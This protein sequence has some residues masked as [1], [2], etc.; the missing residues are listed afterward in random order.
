MERLA[1]I[2]TAKLEAKVGTVVDAFD[3]ELAVVRSMADAPQIDGLV[4][5]QNGAEAG[6]KPGDFAS[7]RSWA[8]TNMTSTARSPEPPERGS[9]EAA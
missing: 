7:Y 2:F 3:G 4:Q 5:L 1:E 9:R 8:A 6:L